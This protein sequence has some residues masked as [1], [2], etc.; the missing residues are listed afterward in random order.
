MIA[1]LIKNYSGIPCTNCT[2]PIPVSKKIA[3]LHDELE[4]RDASSPQTFIARCQQCEYE[5]IYPVAEIQSFGGE[6][7]KRHSNARSTGA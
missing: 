6:P 3:K 5:S 4:S 1:E 7:R 2:E